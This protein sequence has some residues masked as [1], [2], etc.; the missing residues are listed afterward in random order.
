MLNYR[1]LSLP[2]PLPQWGKAYCS[3]EDPT[4]EIKS[5]HRK[6]QGEKSANG[7]QYATVTL[8][9]VRER[10][11]PSCTRSSLKKELEIKMSLPKR[12]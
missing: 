11:L 6:C 12:A 3:P 9:E 10:K 4:S 2:L 7:E 5:H 1:G 8:L